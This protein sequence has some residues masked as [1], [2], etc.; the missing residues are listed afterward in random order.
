[1]LEFKAVFDHRLAGN[2][3]EQEVAYAQRLH[4]ASQLGLL[5]G[6]DVEHVVKDQDL[7]GAVGA[8]ADAE[9][10]QPRVEQRG[11]DAVPLREVG[12]AAAVRQRAGFVRCGEALGRAAGDAARGGPD[13]R[14]RPG[15]DARLRD[16]EG[17]AETVAAP[18]RPSLAIVGGVV[19]DP[20]AIEVPLRRF[21]AAD[22]EVDCTAPLE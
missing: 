12:D 11:L 10:I 2:G 13:L 21:T 9:V 8:A 5:A 18:W 4:F 17:I 20:A 1:M 14:L 16:S 15:P 6:V 22:R 3:Q 7:A 19:H